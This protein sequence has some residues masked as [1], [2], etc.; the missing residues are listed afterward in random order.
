[1][2]DR[3]RVKAQFLACT[4]GELVQIK[5]CR[6]ALMPFQGKLL[7]VVAEIPHE[8]HRP[9]LPIQ[10]AVQGF[11]AVAKHL[12]H[13]RIIPYL[14]NSRTKADRPSDGSLSLPALKD[15]VSRGESR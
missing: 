13:L 15:G 5:A 14:S 3:P 6:P 4:R 7:S 8:I 10:K 12:N 11:N 1:M 9:A 2:I